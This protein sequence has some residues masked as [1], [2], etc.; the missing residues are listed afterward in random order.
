MSVTPRQQVILD[1]ALELTREAGLAGLTMKRIAERVGF[2]EPALY[3]HFPTKQDLLLGLVDRMEGM[4][5]GGV[6]EIAAGD[7]PP[8]V[9]LERVLGH[10]V[11]LVLRTDGL[12]FL[13]LAEA[14]AGGNRQLGERL[15]GVMRPYVGQLAALLAQTPGSPDRPP[16][17]EVAFLFLGVPAMLAIHHR[18]AP[19]PSLERRLARDLVPY[20]VER[21]TGATAAR[22]RPKAE[23]PGPASRLPSGGRAGPPGG[24]AKRGRPAQLGERGKATR[25]KERRR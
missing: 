6:R 2:T 5:L 15:L 7:D 22:A 11:D 17:E 8:A 16:P 4:L 1:C 19:D 18:L 9:K 14:A 12:P 10:H 13:L 23:V 25:A 24:R 21:V 20:L 3:R